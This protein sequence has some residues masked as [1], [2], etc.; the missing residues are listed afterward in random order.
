MFCPHHG[1][2][3]STITRT[4]VLTHAIAEMNLENRKQKKPDTKDY[5]S[6][7][8]FS[9]EI[10]RKGNSIQIQNRLMV[11]RG[12][13]GRN[14]ECMLNA[15]MSSFRVMNTFWNQPHNNVKCP[16]CHGTLHSARGKT[17]DSML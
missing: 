6:H 16:K 12:W 15:D 10:S 2:Y 4:E 7:D 5:I 11:A 9:Y 3:H 17:V 13:W 8:S 14:G 1:V